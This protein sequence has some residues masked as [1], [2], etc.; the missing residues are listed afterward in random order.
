V[1][2]LVRAFD[3]DLAHEAQPVLPLSTISVTEDMAT[4]LTL[5]A[6]GWRSAYTSETLAAG[7]APED[8]GSALRQRL[9]WAQGT[10][11]VMLRQN[12][13]TMRGL[14]TGQRLMYLATMWSYLSGFAALAYIADPPLYL[15]FHVGP[16]ATYSPDYFAHALPYLVACQA[17]FTLTGWRMSTWRGQQYSLSL[18]PLWIQATWSAFAN[19]ALGRALEFQVTPKVAQRGLHAALV[20]PQ[21]TAMG[22][23]LLSIAVGLGRMLVDPSENRV[24]VL[25]NVFWACYLLGMLSVVVGALRY[26]PDAA[27]EMV[28]EVAEAAALP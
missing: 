19:V 6:M 20:W 12:P 11:Q 21:L 24:A 13:L 18:F 25:A 23:L 14:S 2:A 15:L 22:V 28:G 17:L 10:I 9:R 7:L 8:L 26:R 16:I 5:H 4:A 1:P 3:V 27:Q